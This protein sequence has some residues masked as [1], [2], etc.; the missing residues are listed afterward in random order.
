MANDKTSRKYDLV[1]FGATGYT[2]RIT[3]EQV[4]EHTP[5]GLKWAI[6]GRSPQKLEAHAFEYNRLHPDRVPVGVFVSDIDD[7]SADRL[8]KAAR[9]VIT[10][11]GP[12]A[13]YGTSII[14]AC[15]VNGTHYVD[16]TGE[17][18]WVKEMIRRYHKTARTNGA[19]IIPQAGFESAPADLGTYLLVKAI[20]EQLD[21]PTGDVR[22]AL[23]DFVG[24]A[25]GGTIETTLTF[26]DASTLQ[27]VVEAS[28]PLALSPTPRDHYD[29][30]WNP[31]RR[32]KDLGI[33]APWM[34]AIPDRAIV[35]RSWGLRD[36]GYLYG[37]NFTFTE[38]R[39]VGNWF[40]AVWMAIMVCFIAIVPMI[41]P[42]KWIAKYF[43][44][45]PSEGPSIEARKLCRAEWRGVAEADGDDE[46]DENPRKALL[47]VKAAKDPYTITG[48]L[49]V[50]IAL[51][52]LFED[53]EARRDG[54]G[55]LTPSTVSCDELYRGL[56][57]AGLEWEVKLL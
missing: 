27:E 56:E 3:C 52:I 44:T 53:T 2:G 48:L 33:L 24:N 21:A 31:F 26:M 1:V 37:P 41:T 46:D 40:S 47:V 42:A 50:K 18:T 8:A 30:S 5:S 10:T 55:I 43:V 11:V 7:D 19:I 54:G 34:Q 16:C 38:Y 39:R 49:L 23:Y 22:F 14:E 15:A 28:Q 57:R 17:Y 32:D 25:S 20:R 13:K 45:P 51:A 4:L 35:M 29:T 12:F 6:A 9:L 36:R